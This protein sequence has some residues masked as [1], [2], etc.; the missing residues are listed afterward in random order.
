MKKN[1]I[2][3]T[4]SQLHKLIKESVKSFINEGGHLTW[5]DDDGRMH[6]NSQDNWYGIE[7]ATFVSHGAWS[8]GEIYF[9]YEGEQYVI[10]ANDA[11]EWLWDDF[12]EYCEENNLNPDEHSDD[13]IWYNFAR[14]EGY[15]VLLNLGPYNESYE[16]NES[17]KRKVRLTESQLHNIVKKT[18]AK[19][20]NE[21]QT[22]RV[23]EYNIK[24]DDDNKTIISVN[25]WG[26]RDQQAAIKTMGEDVY[27]QALQHLNG[28][29]MNEAYSQ[30]QL[31]RIVKQSIDNLLVEAMPNGYTAMQYQQMANQHNSTGG[32]TGSYHMPSVPRGMNAED[33]YKQLQAE[34]EAQERMKK[35]AEDA[36]Q[37]RMNNINQK[38]NIQEFS[39]Y[40]NKLEVNLAN[41]WR[42]V[43]NN[44]RASRDNEY[45]KYLIQD[46]KRK[47]AKEAWGYAQKLGLDFGEFKDAV[48]CA[49]ENGLYDKTDGLA[50]MV[51]R[52]V[53]GY[54][55]L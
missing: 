10:N 1:R 19:I 33:F 18:I 52:F 25:G 55:D 32:F 31:R 47:Y 50:G 21:S 37:T 34:K 43:Y 4:E 26:V 28:G 24:F 13:E 5:K 41:E 35:N 20:L 6:T 23:G 36:R 51:N 8:D 11:E 53:M 14:N 42:N 22:V 48:S 17:K 38:I 3:L 44:P 46:L 40:M 9:D 7:G 49:R 54:S 16:M 2:R 12:K 30:P 39:E 27:Q 15:D 45:A 29:Y